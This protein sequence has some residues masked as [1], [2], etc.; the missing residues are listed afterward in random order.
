VEAGK[1]EPSISGGKKHVLLVL[2]LVLLETVENLEAQQSMDV[3]RK[4]E[5]WAGLRMRFDLMCLI[6]VVER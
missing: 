5:Y 4:M 1:S 3:A 2:V 6:E